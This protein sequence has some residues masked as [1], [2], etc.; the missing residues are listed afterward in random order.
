MVS[1]IE[2]KWDEGHSHV[3]R[4]QDPSGVQDFKTPKDRNLEGK[5]GV[6]KAIFPIILCVTWRGR[7]WMPHLRCIGGQVEKSRVDLKWLEVDKI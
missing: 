6:Q 7:W 1:S 4:F 3:A 5:R 2:S